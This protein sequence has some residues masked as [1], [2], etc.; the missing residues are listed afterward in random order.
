MRYFSCGNCG[1][2]V[3]FEN[4]VC[5]RCSTQLR[6]VP[7][8]LEL[9]AIGFEDFSLDCA[10]RGLAG[11]NWV[12]IV[13]GG[14][15]R[16]CRLTRVRPRDEDTRGLEAFVIAERAKRRAL[17][18]LLELGVPD[19]AEGSL[20]FDLL[21]SEDAPVVTGHADGV[22][23]IDLA[24][25]D[26]ARREA[27]RAQLGE[28]YR[29]MLGHLRHELGHFAQARVLRGA[30]DW[31]AARKLFGDERADYEEAL[32]RH[33][34]QGPP[35]DWATHHVSAYAAMH[36]WEDWAETFA[37]Y[38]HIHDTLQSAAAFG[39]RVDGP[40]PGAVRQTLAS[41]P[42]REPAEVAFEEVL[43]AWMPLS[44]VLNAISR[45]MGRDDL[46]PFTLAAPVI[47]KLEFVHDRLARLRA[48]PLA[49]VGAATAAED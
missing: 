47:A 8:R 38:L 29:T 11:C 15:C 22:I 10:N 23:T 34:S 26:D 49:G 19:V 41:S 4:T 27:R 13:P 30:A 21:S 24:E 7:E 16:S 36:P 37:H 39:V 40:R 12:A 46:Y 9:A 6:F 45:S 3:F 25:G 31:D 42:P 2:G 5:L 43:A 17:A 1:G 20:T 33:Y 35:A 32:D 14:L 48:G 28:A 44:T 18:Q